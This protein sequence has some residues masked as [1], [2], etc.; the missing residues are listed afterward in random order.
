M[1]SPFGHW[2]NLPKNRKR[3]M[4]IVN[5]ATPTAMPP[6]FTGVATTRTLNNSPWSCHQLFGAQ[7]CG[8]FSRTNMHTPGTYRA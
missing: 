3:S 1:S 7:M 2:S 4:F 8:C 6:D 5:C